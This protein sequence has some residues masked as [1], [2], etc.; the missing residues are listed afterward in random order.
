[1]VLWWCGMSDCLRMI[2]LEIPWRWLCKY[3][4]T[5]RLYVAKTFSAQSVPVTEG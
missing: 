4:Q 2:A 3:V 1:M 5:T